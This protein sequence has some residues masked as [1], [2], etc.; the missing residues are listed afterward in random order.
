MSRALLFIMLL[1]GYVEAFCIT[2]SEM[3]VQRFGNNM[4]QWCSTQKIDYRKAVLQDCHNKKGI[5]KKEC[6]AND[7]LMKVEAQ[8][9]N[10]SNKHYVIM[11]YLNVFQNAFRLGNI[12]FQ[13]YNIRETEYESIQMVKPSLKKI[14]FAKSCTYV[15]CDI[16][17][18]GVL[19]YRLKNLFIISE[20]GKIWSIE[21]RNEIVDRKTGKKK[22]LVDFDNLIEHY[23]SVGFTY[24]YG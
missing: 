11:N 9:S 4:A 15:A 6:T 17:V 19:N 23:E 24:N 2:D 13:M 18:N 8:K 22:I 20:E 14:P 1:V 3:I 5:L 16:D 12:S 10:L 7:Y 21:T